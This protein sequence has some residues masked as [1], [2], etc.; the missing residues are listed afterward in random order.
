MAVALRRLYIRYRQ[1]EADIP[2]LSELIVDLPGEKVGLRAVELCRELHAFLYQD[3]LVNAGQYRR[4]TDPN[5]GRVDFGGRKGHTV[6]PRYIGTPPERIEEGMIEAGSHLAWG[7][8]P[9][10]DAIRFY[11]EMSAV[12]PF[13]DA[14]GRIGRLVVSIYLY[15]YELYVN[16]DEIDQRHGQF[17]QKLNACHDRRGS[18]QK[19]LYEEYV[20]YL[21][22]FFEKHVEPHADF[23]GEDE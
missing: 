16:W 18:R 1:L 4:V 10:A 22:S 17:M 13:Y 9:V 14:N 7:D 19:G 11:L 20:G 15:C 12:H 6:R 2:R 5:G 21:T 23:M 3:F 8:D